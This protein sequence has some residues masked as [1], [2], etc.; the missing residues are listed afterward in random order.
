MF[1]LN[2]L[3]WAWLDEKESEARHRAFLKDCEKLKILLKRRIVQIDILTVY[4]S[5]LN[6]DDTRDQE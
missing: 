3:L 5:P 1:A 2:L 4:L 6:S